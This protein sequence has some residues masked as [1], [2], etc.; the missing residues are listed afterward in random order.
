M[1]QSLWINA[2][3]RIHWTN[4]Q[5]DTRMSIK[6]KWCHLSSVIYRKYRYNLVLNLWKAPAGMEHHFSDR[7]FLIYSLMV[8]VPLFVSY[9][10][11][12][13]GHQMFP[14]D[15]L[16]LP[17]YLLISFPQFIVDDTLVIASFTNSQFIFNSIC[18]LS[19]AVHSFFLI[20][21]VFNSTEQTGC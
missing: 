13:H 18:L 4:H 6:K 5:I 7:Y 10:C 16:S 2:C 17:S 1:K 14:V 8:T 15:H 11:E 3:Y 19:K 9:L 12:H 20:E 21:F